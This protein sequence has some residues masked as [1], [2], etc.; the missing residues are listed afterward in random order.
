MVFEPSFVLSLCTVVATVAV[1]VAVSAATTKFA[2]NRITHLE[3]RMDKKFD[4]VNLRF[5][6]LENRITSVENRVIEVANLVIEVEKDLGLVK[7]DLV[8]VTGLCRERNKSEL[9]G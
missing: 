3:S 1:Y 6:S 4:E 9:P 8:T 2:N 5:A 7:A